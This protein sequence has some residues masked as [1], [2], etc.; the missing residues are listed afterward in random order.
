LEELKVFRSSFTRLFLL[1]IGMTMIT[2]SPAGGAT[3][4]SGEGSAFD[5]RVRYIE[6]LVEHSSVA[7][8][9]EA[10]MN[11]EAAAKRNAARAYYRQ[12]RDAHNAG[13]TEFAYQLLNGAM[14]DMGE[15]A[16]LAARDEA[17][18][19]KRKQDF[20][21]RLDTVNALLAAHDRIKS[22]SGAPQYSD[23]FQSSIRSDVARAEALFAQGDIGVARDQLDGAYEVLTAAI[24]K[25]R[26]GHTLVHELH[27]ATKKDEYHYE[28]GRNRSH[29]ML[30]KVL[31]EDKMR[32]NPN[33]REIVRELMNRA[34][35]ALADAARYAE[36]GDYDAA[37][38]A[39]ETSTAHI[40]RA[41][42]G[43]G[44]YIPG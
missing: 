39:L 41:I 18:E 22:E 44:I 19:E 21:V 17:L 15:A 14:R 26:G 32:S 16:R 8:K 25:I 3:P 11:A 13:D 24:E 33:D 6:T 2:T 7:R 23:R 42:R 37:I 9:V 36:V 28:T 30:V 40:V 27:F 20:K 43:A 35:D 34:D 10:S 12:A 31:L 4:T 29:R 5:S 38:A 1:L